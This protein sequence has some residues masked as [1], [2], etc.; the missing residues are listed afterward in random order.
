[1]GAQSQYFKN[2]GDLGDKNEKLDT[3]VQEAK[4]NQSIPLQ[5]LLEAVN[6]ASI[7]AIESDGWLG[8]LITLA[9]SVG[10]IEDPII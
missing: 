4:F 2:L 5:S 3:I 9:E 6:R 1:M 10:A 8:Q 7:E